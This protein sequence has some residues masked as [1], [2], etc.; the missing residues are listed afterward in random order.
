MF[1]LL[2]SL[3]HIVRRNN[4]IYYRRG[5]PQSLRHRYKCREIKFSLC[6]ADLFSQ[7]L[8]K[9]QR[10]AIMSLEE[11]FALKTRNDRQKRNEEV[12]VHMVTESWDTL[13]GTL[14]RDPPENINPARKA[15]MEA[16]AKVFNKENEKQKTLGET[17]EEYLQSPPGNKGP[18]ALKNMAGILREFLNV[19]GNHGTR[20]VREIT[21]TDV[22]VYADWLK[23][24]QLADKT[25]RNKIM[26]VSQFFSWLDTFE[27]NTQHLEKIFSIFP[28]KKASAKKQGKSFSVDQ[29]RSVTEHISQF[30]TF[31][32]SWKGS[33]LRW[34]YW[35]FLMC[36]FQGCRVGEAAQLH[37]DDILVYEKIPCISI[38]EGFEKSVKNRESKRL[39][40][41]HPFLFEQGFM[42]Y[43]EDRKLRLAAGQCC[44]HP[45]RL[46]DVGWHPVNG[47]AQSVSRWFRESCFPEIKLT[48]LA[49]SD[50]RH[51]WETKVSLLPLS[52]H[53]KRIAARISGRRVE[54]HG[55]PTSTIA[56]MSRHYI[57]ED[58]PPDMMLPVL[59]KVT[60]L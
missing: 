28:G 53:E 35:M 46:F 19:M 59:E 6:S 32:D 56:V 20:P 55:I 40:P 12:L 27:Y 58:Y 34:R 25:K 49:L 60:F 11:A 22:A 1:L 4:K 7:M 44:S 42:E 9:L 37:H 54:V 47:C 2:I 39:I 5:V 31:N 16:I 15:V 33:D 8:P 18:S 41:V 48:G 24:S 3:P 10:V 29:I 13:A 45:H 14:Y 30:K 17:V 38:T 50:L 26:W 52:D 57:T 43:C 51:T 21:R 23:Q 36:L